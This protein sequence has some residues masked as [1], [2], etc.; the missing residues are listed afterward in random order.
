MPL[1]VDSFIRPPLVT[2][3]IWKRT[4]VFVRRAGKC[5]TVGTGSSSRYGDEAEENSARMALQ[6]TGEGGLVAVV[7]GIRVGRS[8][9]VT[10]VVVCLVVASAGVEVV[11]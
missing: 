2:I 9:D 1:I 10:A 5:R 8:F 11:G 4:G 7:V 6:L 3:I